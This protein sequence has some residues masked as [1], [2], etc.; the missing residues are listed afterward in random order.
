MLVQYLGPMFTSDLRR[1]K[2]IND[3]NAVTFLKVI[4]IYN[5]SQNSR[6][7]SILL[8]NTNTAKT[9]SW[10][11]LA[12]TLSRLKRQ[13]MAGFEIVNVFPINPKALTL[14]ELYGEYNLGTGE[15]KDGVLSSVMRTVC[16]GTCDKILI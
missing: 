7:S 14:G 9:V 11:M 8:G 4:Q 5:L 6:H 10:K 13:K 2:N 15:W 3:I 1:I 16:Q 12:A